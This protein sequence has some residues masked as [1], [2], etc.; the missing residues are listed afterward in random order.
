MLSLHTHYITDITSLSTLGYLLFI[1]S[2]TNLIDVLSC[3]HKLVY[4]CLAGTCLL[5]SSFSTA[6]KMIT[7]LQEP[8]KQLHKII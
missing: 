1:C 5:S 8:L 2:S 7:I 6:Q 4:M 3:L